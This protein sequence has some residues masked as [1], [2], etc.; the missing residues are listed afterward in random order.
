MSLYYH[1]RE[2]KR[3]REIQKE[4]ER[5]TQI[6]REG[7][8]DRERKNRDLGTVKKERDKTSLLLSHCFSYCCVSTLHLPVLPVPFSYFTFSSSPFSFFIEANFM[9]NDKHI[10]Y[11]NTKVYV[12]RYHFGLHTLISINIHLCVFITYMF[13]ITRMLNFL[14]ENHIKICMYVFNE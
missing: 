10:S 8:I 11:K 5:E 3:D 7:K 9:T 2:R 1:K 6:D 4:K 13:I 12:Y 14:L